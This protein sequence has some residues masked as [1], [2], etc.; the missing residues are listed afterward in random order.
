MSGK[1]AKVKCT[2][3]Q[4]EVLE[5]I[6]KS[7]R[8]EARMITRAKIIRYSFDGKRNC[9]ISEIVE[10][11][12]GQVGVWRKRWKDSFDAL[13][14]I[15]CRETTAQ[16]VRSIEDVLSDA[17][18]SGRP[19]TFTPEQVTQILA[20]ACEDPALSGRPVSLWTHCLALDSLS[21]FGLTGKLP[22]RSS[23]EKSLNA[24]QLVKL[25]DTSTSRH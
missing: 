23:S 14:A 22:M 12:R 19:P 2:E 24:S 10:L 3:K 8:S 17:P 16:L 15:E 7:N 13:V 21:R 5:Q 9:E 20:V 11:D 4:I 18:R 6:I 1:A 25:V